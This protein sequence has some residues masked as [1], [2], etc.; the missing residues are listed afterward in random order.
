MMRAGSL[1]YRTVFFG[2]GVAALI[3]AVTDVGSGTVDWILGVGWLVLAVFGR[4]HEDSP[5]RDRS[6]GGRVRRYFGLGP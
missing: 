6:V 1:G 3:A 5:S 4:S 2:F